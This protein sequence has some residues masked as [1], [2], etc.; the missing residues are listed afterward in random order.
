MEKEIFDFLKTLAEGSGLINEH[1]HRAEAGEL[2]RKYGQSR[3]AAVTPALPFADCPTC[4]SQVQISTGKEGTSHFVTV[5]PA[6]PLS[7][8]CGAEMK[9]MRYCVKCQEWE[10]GNDR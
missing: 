2:L 10:G 7:K 8:C 1:Y 9:S 4:G 5:A 6:L 3:Q